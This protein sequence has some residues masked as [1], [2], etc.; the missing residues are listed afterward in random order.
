MTDQTET[1][2]PF[3]VTYAPAHVV[4]HFTK[5]VTVRC[6]HENN[7]RASQLQEIS[8]IRLLKRSSSGW[9]LLAEMRDNENTPKAYVNVSVSARISSYIPYNFIEIVWPVATVATFGIYRCDFIGFDQRNFENKAEVTP[10]VMLLEESVT[11]FDMLNM[12]LETKDE[13]KHI[14]EDTMHLGQN[15]AG[16][17]DRLAN[18]SKEV[19]NQD[20]DISGLGG[21]MSTVQRSLNLVTGVAAVYKADLNSLKLESNAV[22]QNENKMTLLDASI[23]SVKNEINSMSVQSGGPVYSDVRFSSLMSWPAGKYAL[24]QPKTGCPVDLTFFGGSGKYWQIHTESS[25]SSANRNAHT[26]ALSPW[27]LS[28][29]GSNNFA[30]VKFCEANGILNTE[31][32][33]SGSYCINRIFNVPCP[34]GFGEGEIQLDV[35][36]TNPVTEYTSQSVVGGHSI[37]FCCMSSGTASTG[38]ALPTRSPFV[39]YRRGGHCQQVDGMIVSDESLIVDTEDTV[40]GDHK[41]NNSPD[42]DIHQSGDSIMNIH[43]CYYTPA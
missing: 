30:T 5:L 14:E 24:L 10:I 12:F 39:L 37:L 9:Q 31:S 32:W 40:N 41:V 15:A 1:S 43:L 36:D 3:Q 26:D 25:S 19:D 42:V 6:A 11:T 8:R 33:P 27:T 20:A 21:D 4:R 22:M 35:E 28:T 13:L 34:S 2:S 7:N 23:K 29:E 38:I 17:H 16:L 18:I